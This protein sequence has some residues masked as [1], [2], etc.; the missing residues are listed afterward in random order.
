MDE[1][2]SLYSNS[3]SECATL[4]L[5]CTLCLC[6]LFPFGLRYKDLG[7]CK[8]C[9]SSDLHIPLNSLGSRHHREN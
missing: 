4:S 2:Q 6:F 3:L 9:M 5:N 1:E 7:P 8:V